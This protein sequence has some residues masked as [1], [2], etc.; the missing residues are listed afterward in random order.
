[1]TPD[2]WGFTQS[3][4]STQ[5]GPGSCS[6]WPSGRRASPSLT[7]LTDLSIALY[8]QS[9]SLPA[10][11]ALHTSLSTP[12]PLPLPAFPCLDGPAVFFPISR[13]LLLFFLTNL[14]LP[15][16][17]PGRCLLCLPQHHGYSLLRYQL[18]F[19]LLPL[20][21]LSV[22]SLPYDKASVSIIMLCT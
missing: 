21:P 9:L 18:I 19:L 20:A 3:E 7:D 15:F 16:L 1:M 14:R 2:V 6:E 10:L 4:L 17:P 12:T 13:S 22:L 8:R 5:S 11:S